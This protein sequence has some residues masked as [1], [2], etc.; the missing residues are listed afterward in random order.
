MKVV[1]NIGIPKI[2]TS[3]ISVRI[4]TMPKYKA[5]HMPVIHEYNIP[6]VFKQ[7]N[8]YVP[9]SLQS[10]LFWVMLVTFSIVALYSCYSW[11]GNFKFRVDRPGNQVVNVVR[12][13][14]QKKRPYVMSIV[15]KNNHKE[16]EIETFSLIDLDKNR[17]AL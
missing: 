5:F 17:E 16:K 6:K 11:C 12:Q 9:L 15:T 2:W 4:P 1:K 3:M 8:R 7:L 10:V 14:E 13:T